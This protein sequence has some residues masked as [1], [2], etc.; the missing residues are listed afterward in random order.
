MRNRKEI[1]TEIA[2]QASPGVLSRLT[3]EVL[4]D[5]RELL[6]AEKKETATAPIKAKATRRRSGE[7]S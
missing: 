3:I 6:M 4:L 1:E 7:Q 5:V 2:P